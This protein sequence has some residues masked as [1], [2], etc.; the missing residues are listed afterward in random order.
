MP[1]VVLAPARLEGE[2]HETVVR[3]LPT[4][5]SGDLAAMARADCLMV[6]APGTVSL[7]A[8][9]MVSVLPK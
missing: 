1:L 4:Q 2:A 5:G 9:A 3:P 6:I 8:G 7:R